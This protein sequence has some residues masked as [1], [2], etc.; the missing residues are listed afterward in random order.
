MR[1]V[2][3]MVSISE[4]RV[5]KRVCSSNNG[6]DEIDIIDIVNLESVKI[7]SQSYFK[8]VKLKNFM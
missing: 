3:E 2:P 1:V 8:I 7:N 5:I 4:G 6:V